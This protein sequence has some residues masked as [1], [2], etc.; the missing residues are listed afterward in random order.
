MLSLEPV[1]CLAENNSQLSPPF[2]LDENHGPGHL[3]SK[4][5]FTSQSGARHQVR[6]G[7]HVWCT[8]TRSS[9]AALPPACHRGLSDGHTP[10]RRPGSQSWTDRTSINPCH[11]H[12]RTNPGPL[13]A[14]HACAVVALV[15]TSVPG[16]VPHAQRKL[17]SGATQNS[18]KPTEPRSRCPG[19]ARPTGSAPAYLRNRGEAGVRTQ[20][21]PP[22]TEKA[23][24]V[25]RAYASG[26]RMRN[27]QASTAT[28]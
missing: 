22:A 21:A 6:P 13:A 23:A 28:P 7:A 14:H 9:T 24:A 17:G 11:P 16:E 20:T 10:Q 27:S 12:Q 26:T 15:L 4:T 3:G 2:Q 18:K 1:L 19:N 25:R 8:R 5:C